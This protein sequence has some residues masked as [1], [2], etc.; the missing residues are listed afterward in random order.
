MT[1]IQ[2]RMQA[3]RYSDRYNTFWY[4]REVSPGVFQPYAH[5]SDDDRT[6]ATFYCGKE[7]KPEPKFEIEQSKVWSSF[8]IVRLVIPHM[9]PKFK[10]S[11]F[12]DDFGFLVPIDFKAIAIH[13][14]EE[15]GSK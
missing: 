5:H 9:G 11:G 6:V 12:M 15:G 3:R 2:A 4:V 14:R 13:L 8:H 1:K 7:W 10:Y